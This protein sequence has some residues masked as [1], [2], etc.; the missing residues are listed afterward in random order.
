MFLIADLLIASPSLLK[1]KTQHGSLA[2][3]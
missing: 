3:F 2:W 1:S